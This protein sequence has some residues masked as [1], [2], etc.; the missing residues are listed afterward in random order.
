MSD[1]TEASGTTTLKLDLPNALQIAATG[2]LAHIRAV[3]AL[4]AAAILIG[5]IDWAAMS[6]E[7]QDEYFELLMGINGNIH[8]A[9]CE[10]EGEL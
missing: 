5:N 7:K 9:L 1:K 3:G 10:F 2:E 6:A 4:A 8:D